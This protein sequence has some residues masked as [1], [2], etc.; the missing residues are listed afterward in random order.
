MNKKACVTIVL[1]A[2]LLGSGIA[3]GGWC[4][5]QQIVNAIREQEAAQIRV[6]KQAAELQ[7]NSFERRG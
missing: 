6:M 2:L 3:A 5:G 7:K 4:I 1:S